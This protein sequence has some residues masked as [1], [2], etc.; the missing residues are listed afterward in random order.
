MTNRHQC[1]TLLRHNRF[2]V[3]KVEVDQTTIRD[4]V[5]DS[6]DTLPQYVVGHAE[7]F[8]HFGVFRGDL[9]QAIIRHHDQRVHGWL[10]LL[11]A[12]FGHFAAMIA[13][14]REWPRDNANRQCAQF[15]RDGGDN[16]RCA[17]ARAAAHPS[18]HKHHIRATQHFNQFI[19]GFFGGFLADHRI[20][21]RTQTTGQFIADPHPQC[22]WRMDESLSI[23]VDGDEFNA[24]HT[25]LNHPINGVRA[26][27]AHPN[28]FDLSKIFQ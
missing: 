15:L 8:V 25:G 28:H 16:W 6:L 23:G 4:Q 26:A 9:Q 1:C 22:G 17:R 14:E 21:A 10:E 24:L 18:G 19:M 27:A 13:L 7:G 5:G 11:D 3:G 20:A 12:R 2:H